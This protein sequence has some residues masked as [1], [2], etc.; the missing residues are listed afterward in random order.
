MAPRPPVD[1]DN[2]S[3]GDWLRGTIKYGESIAN[4]PQADD[5]MKPREAFYDALKNDPRANALSAFA[6]GMRGT[7]DKGAATGWLMNRLAPDTGVPEEAMRKMDYALGQKH[8][9]AHLVGAGLGAGLSAAD[10]AISTADGI[11]GIKWLGGFGAT[12]PVEKIAETT[13]PFVL[14]ADGKVAQLATEAGA[15][16][17]QLGK[18]GWLPRLASTAGNAAVKF[19]RA[20][21][22]AATVGAMALGGGLGNI[23]YNIYSNNHYPDPVD[24]AAATAADKTKQPEPPKPDW[25]DE[26]SGIT[27]LSRD[28]LQE[29]VRQDGGIRL[30]TIQAFSGMKGRPQTPQQRAMDTV[31]TLMRGKIAEALNNGD[32]EGARKLSATAASLYAQIAGGDDIIGSALENLLAGKN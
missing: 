21:P 31:D 1:I 26:M 13:L 4:Q 14:G 24:P 18:A 17:S 8:P 7:V 2:P 10:W 27:G 22:I 9:V 23:G 6:M 3:W 32:T 12:K 5:T 29:M 25:Y 28:T 19:A 15:G 30:S 20:N 11:N 16:F